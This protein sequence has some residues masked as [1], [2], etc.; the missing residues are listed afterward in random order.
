[1][2]PHQDLADAG[3]LDGVGDQVGQH[4]AE[5]GGVADESLRHVLL[6]ADREADAPLPRRLGEEGRGLVDDPADLEVHLLQLELAG[7]DLGEVEDVVDDAEQRAPGALDALG[8]AALVVAEAGALQQLVEA[9]HAVERGA[10]LVRHGGQELRLEPRGLH[11]RVPRRRQLGGDQLPL[12]HPS[13]LLGDLV[14]E[15]AHHR[16]P[17]ERRGRGDHHDDQRPLL[18]EDDERRRR[19]LRSPVLL[20]DGA[21]GLECA[22]GDLPLG[23]VGLRVV[24]SNAE[25]LEPPGAVLVGHHGERDPAEPVL[26]GQQHGPRDP[27]SVDQASRPRWRPRRSPA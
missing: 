18:L 4:L 13:E 23:L 16:V 9:D 12:G 19:R 26:V 24:G 2:G 8:E 11:R 15:G 6:D 25:R 27:E 20:E 17:L 7:L 3:E 5:P 14:A 22:A 10:D 1:M 21:A